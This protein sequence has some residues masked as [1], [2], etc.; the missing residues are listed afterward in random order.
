M[1]VLR[2]RA[3][4]A[5]I[6][7][8]LLRDLIEQRILEVSDGGSWNSALYG[9]FIVAEPGDSVAALEAES[10]CCLLTGRFTESPFGEPGFVPS[11]EFI[12]EHANCYEG[13]WILSDDGFGVVILIPKVDGIDPG[14]MSM[15]VTYAIRQSTA[16]GEPGSADTA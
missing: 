4:V 15:C 6:A 1:R 5:Q 10:G 13:V 7:D 16:A 11:F 9:Y 8:S 3:D 12:E 2:E 14:L